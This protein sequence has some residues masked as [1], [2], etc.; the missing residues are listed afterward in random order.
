MTGAPV[1]EALGQALDAQ[2]ERL[3]PCVHCG[4][5]LPACPTYNRLGNE[6]DS[7]RGRLHLMQ[8]VVE[9][10]LEPSSEAFRTHIDRCLGCRACEPVCPSGVEYGTLLELARETATKA[11]PQGL[12]TRFLLKVLGTRALRSPFFFIGRLLRGTGL[13][14]LGATVLPSYRPFRALRLVLAMLASTTRWQPM[15]SEKATS[16][17]TNSGRR[18]VGRESRVAVLLGCVQEGLFT[19]INSATVRVL[20]ANG[21]E[22]VLVE[23]QDCCGALHAHGG[24]LECARM[25]A[26][27]NIRAFEESGADLIAVNAAGCGAAMKDYGI[28]LE[29]DPDFV[30]RAKGVAAS[31]RDVTEILASSGPRIGASVPCKIAYD[32]PCHLL[33]AQGVEQAPITVLEAVPDAEVHVVEGAE[34]CCGGA[35]IYGIT[36][37]KLGGLIGEDKVSAVRA[38]SADAVATPNPG[39][40]MQIGAGLRLEA[41]TEGVLHPIELLDESYRRAGFYRAGGTE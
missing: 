38:C 7:P 13:A 2:K 41:S 18:D 15:V 27:S 6:A 11:A 9:G 35:G 3:L 22:V 5:C 12:P 33:H 34:E 26:R 25:L 29:G 16:G 32:H 1:Y 20:E 10:R 19:R 40:M 14:T 31:V 23:G 17:N 4:F 21:Y 24:D 39:C 36:H 28:L 37:P 30:Q 8:A